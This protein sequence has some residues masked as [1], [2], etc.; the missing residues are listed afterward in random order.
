MKQRRTANDESQTSR[1]TSYACEEVELYHKNKAL[2]R[3]HQQ[4]LRH[5]YREFTVVTFKGQHHRCELYG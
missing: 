3:L 1:L 5:A 2:R 4:L